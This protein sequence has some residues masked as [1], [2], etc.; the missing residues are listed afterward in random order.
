MRHQFDLL[1]FDWDGTL[2]DSIDRIVHCLASAAADA[3][4]Q[5]QPEH[6]LRNIIGLGL[7]EAMQSLYPGEDE[8]TILRLCA[9]YRHHFVELGKGDSALFE[10]VEAMLEELLGQG[11]K[12]AVATGKARVG[13]E[14]VFTHTGY[15]RFFHASRCADETRSKPHPQMLHEL[16]QELQVTPART[17]MIG[18]TEYDLQMASN[19]GIASLGVSY[20]VH[21][22]NR[23][24][25]HNPLACVDTVSELQALLSGSREHDLSSSAGLT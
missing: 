15:N 10:G 5:Q 17:L 7:T 8:A 16:M 13:L 23:L 22:C 9:A 2:M 3:G 20:G 11:F 4:V 1:V 21:D 25:E 12:L 24:W 19:A 18:D 6:N 14:R